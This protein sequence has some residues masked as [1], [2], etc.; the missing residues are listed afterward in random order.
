MWEWFRNTKYLAKIVEAIT[1]KSASAKDKSWGW[2]WIVS[3]VRLPAKLRY[4]F[5]IDCEG[6]SYTM[7]ET[8]LKIEIFLTN[9]NMHSQT[10]TCTWFSDLL[11]YLMCLKINQL[12]IINT[13][14]WLVRL[15]GLNAGLRCK[16]SLAGFPV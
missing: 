15:N 4:S 6:N 11:P 5:S 12:K 13:L 8:P 1:L 2:R 14:P 7:K 16:G 10:V 3:Y 9:A